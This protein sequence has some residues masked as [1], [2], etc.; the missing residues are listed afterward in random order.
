VLNVVQRSRGVAGMQGV[1]SVL[2][3]QDDGGVRGIVHMKEKL[4]RKKM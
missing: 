2:N 1:G 3:L 4:K